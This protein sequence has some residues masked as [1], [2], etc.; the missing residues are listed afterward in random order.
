MNDLQEKY[1]FKLTLSGP[2]T[3][4]L[5]FKKGGFLGPSLNIKIINDRDAILALID[6][7]QNNPREPSQI[8]E[9]NKKYKKYRNLL[10]N[11]ISM[12][13]KVANAD[14][15]ILVE[16]IDVVK[17]F[18]NNVLQVEKETYHE[19]IQIFNEAINS[20]TNIDH[21]AEQIKKEYKDEKE[22][23]GLIVDTLFTLALSDDDF[24]PEEEKLIIAVEKIFGIKGKLY[25]QFCRS[26]SGYSTDEE[27][28]FDIS[29][30][31]YF[32]ILGLESNASASDIKSA[33]RKM[34]MKYHPD[35]N[36]HETSETKKL[37]TKKFQEITDAYV[38][39]SKSR[40]F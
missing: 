35:K 22:I 23:L 38:C 10:N 2:S 34:A 39:L 4:H 5:K 40:N 8:K 20:K 19:A 1:S 9:N 26:R 21:Y 25:Q 31:E 12:L 16:E 30:E 37:Y 14:C 17:D 15:V 24:H 13:S 32:K 3:P 33:F 27:F 6:Y 28:D 7:I 29:E 36:Q 11:S 18:L